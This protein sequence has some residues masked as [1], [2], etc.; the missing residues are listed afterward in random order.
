M[1][2]GGKD[3]LVPTD[4][5]D[6]AHLLRRSGFVAPQAKVDELSRLNLAAAV[7]AVLDTS[8]APA[9]RY[10]ASTDGWNGDGQRAY[11]QMV[12]IIQ[13]WL[14]RMV[15][16]PTPIVEKMCLFL[17]GHVTT[18][19]W[20]VFHTPTMVRWLK[21]QRRHAL[22]NY[23]TYIR[24][25]ATEPA[26]LVY[27]DNANNNV[28]EPNQNFARELMELFLLGVGN[29]SED[30]VDAASRAWTGYN[31]DWDTY[32]YHFYPDRHD[33]SNKTFFGKTRNWNGPQIIDEIL[34]NPSKRSVIGRFMARKAWEFF[35]YQ[36]PSSAI[37]NELGQ[38]FVDA[39]FEWRP[40]LRAMFLRPEFY[41][42]T[43]KQGRV[44]GPVEWIVAVL[45][46]L[47]RRAGELNPQWWMEEMGQDIMNPP[48]VSGWRPNGY[49]VNSSAF[50]AR[51][52]MAR[53]VAWTLTE[54]PDFLA[55]VRTKTPEAA[56][57]QA[58]RLLNIYPLSTTSRNAILHWYR[59]CRATPYEG[60]AEPS[61]LL[62]MTLMAPELHVC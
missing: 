41:S 35:A 30:D 11:Q 14:D 1:P 45:H 57:D 8:R 38:V 60:W 7:D 33:T 26:M 10:P 61:N 23:A 62:T 29:Y 24:E 56:V 46:G 42:S 2:T 32:Q 5:G 12:D 54:N 22:G 21:L 50:A 20:T 53:H 36:N 47:G 27:L 19:F 4:K 34:T 18:S 9:D 16:T 31:L 3:S 43:A 48:N 28:W 15:S 52:V 58:A 59:A 51:A 17:H 49:W 25:M 44:R 6:I 40:L 55:D 39:N 13:W 37:V